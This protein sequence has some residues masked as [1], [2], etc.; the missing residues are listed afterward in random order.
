MYSIF[1]KTFK[2][3]NAGQQYPGTFIVHSVCIDFFQAIQNIA[4]LQLTITGKSKYIL[5]TKRV[6]N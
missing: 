1:H 4:H 3:G 2:G 6:V 5:V